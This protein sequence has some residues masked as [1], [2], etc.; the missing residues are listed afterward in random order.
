[1][2]CDT[3]RLIDGSAGTDGKGRLADLAAGAG[4]VLDI[5]ECVSVRTLG[6]GDHLPGWHLW[7]AAPAEPVASGRLARAA[8]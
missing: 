7:F 3:E 1:V 2:E 8:G 6:N 5:S 4:A